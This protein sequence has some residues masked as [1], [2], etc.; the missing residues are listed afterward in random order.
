VNVVEKD[1]E[2]VEVAIN[3]A[4]IWVGRVS[5]EDNPDFVKSLHGYSRANLMEEDTIITEI[6]RWLYPR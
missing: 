4:G 5:L 1:G 2:P 6:S 3:W